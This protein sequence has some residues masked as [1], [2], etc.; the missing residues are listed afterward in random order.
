MTPAVRP[1]GVDWSTRLLAAAPT[2]CHAA[3]SRRT[4]IVSLGDVVGDPD[5]VIGRISPAVPAKSNYAVVVDVVTAG[6]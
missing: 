3:N 4:L 5:T 2:P 6:E 1:A